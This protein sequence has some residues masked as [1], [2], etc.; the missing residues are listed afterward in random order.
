MRGGSGGVVPESG[1]TVAG[2]PAHDEAPLRAGGALAHL[3]Q[4]AGRPHLAHPDLRLH[5]EVGGRPAGDTA[6]PHSVISH[7]KTTCRTVVSLCK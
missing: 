7:K 4:A 6:S 5:L 2:G 3:V 1:H